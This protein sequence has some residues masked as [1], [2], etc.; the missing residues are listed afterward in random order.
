M[1]KMN[2]NIIWWIL[3]IVIVI[4]ILWQLK[5]IKLDFLTNL[6]STVNGEVTDVASSSG[7]AM[8]S[9]Q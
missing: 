3:G 4:L 2:K 8:S 1:I 5:V 7:G 9:I 6:F